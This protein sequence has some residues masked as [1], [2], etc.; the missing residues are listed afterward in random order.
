MA[1]VEG[2]DAVTFQLEQ[3]RELRVVLYLLTHWKFRASDG[4]KLHLILF[5][6]S[7][8]NQVVGKILQGRFRSEWDPHV[9]F[10]S[11]V[12][13]T[14]SIRR[15]EGINVHNRMVAWL[16]QIVRGSSCREVS[17]SNDGPE[18]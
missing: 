15:V 11:D 1:K 18:K 10:K 14:V 2:E 8:I 4:E 7:I 17:L 3:D 16:L 9:R 12:D 5:E 13:L 6:R